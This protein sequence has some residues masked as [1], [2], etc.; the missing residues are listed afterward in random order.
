[1]KTKKQVPQRKSLSEF[2]EEE[3]KNTELKF[4]REGN[5]LDREVKPSSYLGRMAKLEWII[6]FLDALYEIEENGGIIKIVKK[7][8]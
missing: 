6:A 2:L 7:K 4:Q 8:K 3:G 1:M 5:D